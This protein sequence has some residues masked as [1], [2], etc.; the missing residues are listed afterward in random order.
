MREIRI[1]LGRRVRD[2]YGRT[3]A[4]VLVDG[5]DLGQLLVGVGLA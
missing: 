4:H 5:K 1:E 3:L 2:C